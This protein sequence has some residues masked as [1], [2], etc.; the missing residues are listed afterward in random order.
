MSI[1]YL[2]IEDGPLIL[3]NVLHDIVYYAIPD[4]P[5]NVSENDWKMAGRKDHHLTYRYITSV[6]KEWRNVNIGLRKM[7][8]S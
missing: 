4:D 2:G 6:M 3:I 7:E 8:T 5:T 1:L